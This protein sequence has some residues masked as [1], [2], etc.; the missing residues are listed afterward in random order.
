MYKLVAI[1]LDGTLLNS[2][3]EV[4]KENKE[5]IQELTE[6]G[7]KV[8][9]ASGRISDSVF[10]IAR[11]IG[12]DEYFISGNGAMIYDMREN[13]V[14]YER[15]L[16]K[17]KILELVKMCEENS[18]YYNI[19]TEDAVIA[20]SLNY[21]IAFYNYENQKTSQDKKTNINIVENVYEYIEKMTQTTK[22]LKMTI[23]DESKSI[24]FSI[25]RKLKQISDIDVLEISHMSKKKIKLGTETVDVGYFYTEITKKNV[26]K[27]YAIQELMARE[28]IKQEEVM[29]IGD[30]TNDKMMILQAGF[31]VAMEH[32]NPEVKKVA[33]YITLDNNSSGVAKAIKRSLKM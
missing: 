31:G 26:D 23:C 19:Y 13:N 32:S 15:F 9:L 4:T 33:D 10:Q 3:G 30:N 12:A 21:N 20:K 24:F 16:E 1:D 2:Y 8:V 11:E 22:F 18:I 14:I 17:T 5:A 27:W 28:G 7:I 6:K 29:T 25:M